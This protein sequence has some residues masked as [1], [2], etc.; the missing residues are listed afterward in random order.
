MAPMV[1]MA[2]VRVTH[3]VYLPSRVK[4]KCRES[5]ELKFYWQKSARCLREPFRQRSGSSG[6][7]N[8]K[9]W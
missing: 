4:S 6:K 3:R 1:A 5:S 9:S 2:T 7:L 8:R